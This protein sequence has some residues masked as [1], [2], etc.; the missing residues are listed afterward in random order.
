MKTDQKKQ[1]KSR[2]RF[3]SKSKPSH[4][5]GKGDKPRPSDK[6]E[7]NKNYEKINWSK[8]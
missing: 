3:A 6:N 7:Y 2:C 1:C 4:T 5:N 8:K